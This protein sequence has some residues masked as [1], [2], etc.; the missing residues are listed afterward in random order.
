MP[1]R[2]LPEALWSG[3][4][5]LTALDDLAKAVRASGIAEVGGDVIIDTRLFDTY[6]D[7]TDGIIS[8]IWLNENVIDIVTTAASAGQPAKIDWRPKT[9]AIKVVAEVMTVAENPKPIRIETPAPGEVRVT[10][11]IAAASPPTLNIWHV[12]D[13]A[14]F[15]RTAFIEALRRAGVKVEANLLWPEPRRASCPMRQHC[16]PG[17]KW[18]ST[19][20]RRFPNASRW[21]SRSATI[22]APTCC[23]ALPP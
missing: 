4:D 1:I 5:P 21:F 12:P 23:C 22:A 3:S 19:S 15:A 2:A 20:H 14:A 6:R 10:G 18:R 13:P 7:P 11:E 9:A 8:P 17:P 16:L